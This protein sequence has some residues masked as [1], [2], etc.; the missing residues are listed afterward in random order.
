MDKITDVIRASGMKPEGA[1][2]G[3]PVKDSTG[4]IL[5][6]LSRWT[7]M[8]VGGTVPVAGAGQSL[9]IANIFASQGEKLAKQAALSEVKGSGFGPWARR[10][11]Q[12]MTTDGAADLIKAAHTDNQLYHA[13]M[14]APTS[15]A[16][17]QRTAAQHIQAWLPA[18]ALQDDKRFSEDQ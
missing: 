15:S 9:Q 12:N 17:A 3:G 5:K 6:A 7:G 16:A 10:L 1:V 8:K 13:L 11:F 2:T 18:L 14:I 4:F